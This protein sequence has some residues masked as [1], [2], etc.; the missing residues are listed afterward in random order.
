MGGWFLNVILPTHTT[1]E[2]RKI[3][4]TNL[5]T[6]LESYQL[7]IGVPIHERSVSTIHHCIPFK[8]NPHYWDTQSS[9]FNHVSYYRNINCNILLKNSNRCKKYLLTNKSVIYSKKKKVK[10]HNK[11]TKLNAAISLTSP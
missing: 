7:C 11:P 9:P 10:R 6:V 5:I 1:K 8:I 3:T 4:V 2:V